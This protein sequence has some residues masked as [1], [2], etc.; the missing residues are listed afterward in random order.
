MKNTYLFL[1]FSGIILRFII[2]FLYPTFNVDEISLG[3][4][5]KHLNFIE[6]LYPLE[7][8]QSSPP[9]YLWLQKLIILISPFSFWINIK[10]LSFISSIL[11]ILLFYI[12]INKNNFKP[13]F[14]VLYIILLFNP[15]NLCNSLTV[16]QY[17]I[18]LTG[19]LFLL[20]HFRSRWFN[21]Y[22]WVFFLAWCL[23]SNVGLFSCAGYLIYL[24][25]NQKNAFNF[26]YIK[27]NILTILSP[28]PYIVYFIWYMNQKGAVELKNYM[29]SY[30]SDSFIPIN[31]TIFK[32]L[33]Y[34][35]HGLWIFLFSAFEVWGIFLMLLM[36][37]FFIFINKTDVLF[38]QE[39]TLLFYIVFVHLLLNSFHLYPFS[40][41]LYLYLSPLFVLI[42]GS[43][44]TTLIDLKKIKNP[45]SYLYIPI[46][47]ITLFLYLFYIPF[48]DN[49][50]FSLYKKLNQLDA[51]SIYVTESSQNNCDTFDE[52]TNHQFKNQKTFILVDPNLEKSKYLVSRVAKKIKK[53]VTSREEPIIQNLIRKN[54]IY[55]I[56]SVNGFNIYKI[57]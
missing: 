57:N 10:I 1:L 35:V 50:V 19:T 23:I 42:L 37:P 15:F 26:N 54:K 40:D 4:N 38:K 8:F 41:R 3:N 24:F 34:T 14:L 48:N 18:D 25:F 17:T 11:G 56:D 5:I 22:N 30:W 49:D 28:I 6:L 51:K 20:V 33:L 7:N 13:I 16:K 46:S 47:I 45:L 9:L 21:Q 32:Y 36:I 55:K 27:K 39:I 12:F 29:T 2:Q 44:L 53:N 43:S 52:F 31:S